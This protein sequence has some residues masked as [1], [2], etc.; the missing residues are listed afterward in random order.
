MSYPSFIISGDEVRMLE[1]C[2]VC[3]RTTPVLEPEVKRVAGAEMRGCA[4]EM[5]R[6]MSMDLGG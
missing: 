5:R 1:R 2:P 4:E 3:D 6:V